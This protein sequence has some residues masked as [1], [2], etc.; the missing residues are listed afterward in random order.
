MPSEN[1]SDWAFSEKTALPTPPSTS[2]KV[3]IVSAAS[4]WNRFG[5]DIA[6]PPLRRATIRAHEGDTAERRST[7][8]WPNRFG[9]ETR[10]NPKLFSIASEQSRKTK[11]P[12]GAHYCSGQ[13]LPRLEVI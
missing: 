4:L 10:A 5:S 2:Q 3:P 8:S 11:C 12:N 9:K 1:R 7:L 6:Y 13:C